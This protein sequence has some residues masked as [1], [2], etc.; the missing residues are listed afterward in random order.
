MQTDSPMI[1]STSR[2]LISF[3]A[4]IFVTTAINVVYKTSQTSGNRY[5]F[6]TS[7][8][9]AISEMV[10]MI[11]SITAVMVFD[12]QSSR[13]RL[14]MQLENAWNFITCKRLPMKKYDELPQPVSSTTGNIGPYEELKQFGYIFGLAVA[15]AINN[16]L[17]F[18]LFTRADPATLTLFKSL[19]SLTTAIV[20][21]FALNRPIVK[22]QWFAIMFQCLGMLVFQFDPCKSVPMHSLVTY[23]LVFFSLMLTTMSSV[24][25]DFIL[26]TSTLSLNGVNTMLYMFGFSLNIL[27]FF[28]ESMQGGPGFFEGYNSQA[29]LV[30][31]LN[32]IIG[33]VITAVYKVNIRMCLSLLYN[34]YVI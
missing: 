11:M 12:D 1:H 17:T 2:S 25:N 32:S 20:M 4:L 16:N 34:F 18:N 21:F 23:G 7:G 29:F 24:S 27:Y 26:K 9:L 19:T 14:L 5:S 8:S 33:I 15:Y 10:K 22:V 30:I 3:F 31:F 13:S 28:V 6:S